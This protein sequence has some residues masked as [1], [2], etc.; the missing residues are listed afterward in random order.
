MPSLFERSL[1]RIGKKAHA[2]VLPTAWVRYHELQAG[3]KL[4]VIA[5]D[6]LTIS[7]IKIVETKNIRKK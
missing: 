5:N 6:E 1:I 4:E 3:D 7:P 2:I